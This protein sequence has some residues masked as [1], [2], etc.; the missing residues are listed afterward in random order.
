MG[1]RMHYKQPRWSLFSL[2]GELVSQRNLG[3]FSHY[4]ERIRPYLA[5]G[6]GL[7]SQ[8]KPLKSI[9]KI[10]RKDPLQ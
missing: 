2:W 7:L 1:L 8:G 4:F 3:T 9:I 6:G 10:I 5:F